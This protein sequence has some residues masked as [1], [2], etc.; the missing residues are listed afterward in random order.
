MEQKPDV[1]ESYEKLRQLR[2][3]I[4]VQLNLG[5]MQVRDAWSDVEKDFEKL[6]VKMKRLG[7]RSGEEVQKLRGETRTLIQ[8]ARDR[9]DELR[10]Q[11]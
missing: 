9:I 5:K 10:K 11:I 6:E 3:E 4:K 1:R 8:S 7:E 2:D